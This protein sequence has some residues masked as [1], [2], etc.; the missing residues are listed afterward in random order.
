MK[1]PTSKSASATPAT[2]LPSGTSV[3]T[4]ATA[5]D[6]PPKKKPKGKFD[7]VLRKV[8]SMNAQQFRQSLVAAG[9][10]DDAGKLTE[11]YR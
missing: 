11:K 4:D 2:S 9:I 6:R 5:N 7:A 8:K 1:K 3:P 10:I